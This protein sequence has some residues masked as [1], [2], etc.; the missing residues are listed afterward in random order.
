MAHASFV[1]L[2]FPRPHARRRRAAI[3]VAVHSAG[4]IIHHLF[5]CQRECGVHK[6][7]VDAPSNL[8]DRHLLRISTWPKGFVAEV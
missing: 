7:T 4:C 8:E 1:Y 5:P 2:D 6:C 3:E